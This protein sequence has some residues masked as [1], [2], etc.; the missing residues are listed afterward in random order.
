M[1]KVKVEWQDIISDSKW[2]EEIKEVID[3]F[4]NRICH[5]TGYLLYEDKDI[6]IIGFDVLFNEDKLEKFSYTIIPKKPIKKIKKL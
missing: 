4:K 5:T 6:I 1:K 3:D 2:S